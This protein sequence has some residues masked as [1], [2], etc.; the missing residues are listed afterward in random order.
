VFPEQPVAASGGWTGGDTFK[1]RICFYETP[2]I[3]TVT[4]K[5]EGDQLLFDAQS[6]VG[7]RPTKHPRLVGKAG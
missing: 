1:A 7:F 4:L 5:F 2:F 6:N 3:I